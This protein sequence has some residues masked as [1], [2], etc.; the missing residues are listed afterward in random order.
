MGSVEEASKNWTLNIQLIKNNSTDLNYAISESG[1]KVASEISIEVSPKI[2]ISD[3]RDLIGVKLCSF[4]PQW[5]KKERSMTEFQHFLRE[6]HYSSPEFDVTKYKGYRLRKTSWLREPSELL[7]ES[8]KANELIKLKDTGVRSGDLILF[9]EGYLPVRGEINIPIYIW[10]PT[11]LISSNTNESSQS[12]PPESNIE[13]M[14]EKLNKLLSPRLNYLFSLGEVNI[15]VNASLTDLYQEVYQLIADKTDKIT[16]RF[17]DWIELKSF[18]EFVI[19]ELLPTHLPGKRFWLTYHMMK[20]ELMTNNSIKKLNLKNKKPLIIERLP[21][22]QLIYQQQ[23]NIQNSNAFRIWIQR[24]MNP[25][26]CSEGRALMQPA[27]PPQMVTITGG[28]A[29]TWG[30]L[31]RPMLDTHKDIAPDSIRIYKY[32]PTT[33]LW[34]EMPRPSSANSKKKLENILVGPYNIKEGDNFCFF[35][36]NEFS[37]STSRREYIDNPLSLSISLPEDVISQ[38]YREEMKKKK[39]I[40]QSSNTNNSSSNATSS[41][42]NEKNSKDSPQRNLVAINKPKRKAME[43]VLKLRFDFD[44]DEDQDD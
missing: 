44:D 18:E 4:P 6:N 3:L 29:P 24:L 1:V 34:V 22:N 39:T 12:P 36:L 21:Q 16:S 35:S 33:L 32:N 41:S 26:Q 19:S 17:S 28:S 5:T 2:S 23:M 40:K 13:T 8:D 27:W 14:E 31:A 15:N 7:F 30:H 9:E 43:I 38:Q 10:S 37:S 20:K 11:P 25:D 42:T